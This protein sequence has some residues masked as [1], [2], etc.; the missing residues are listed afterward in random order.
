M[1]SEK[2]APN[3]EREDRFK[4]F[5]IINSKVAV[6][7]DRKETTQEAFDGYIRGLKDGEFCKYMTGIKGIVSLCNLPLFQCPYRSKEQF[8]MYGK[9]KFECR[10]EETVRLRKLL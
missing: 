8:H 1:L 2:E 6:F 4:R 10:R 9:R 7:T 3:S 5:A